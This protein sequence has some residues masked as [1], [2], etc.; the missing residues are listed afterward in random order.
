VRAGDWVLYYARGTVP[1][2]LSAPTDRAE[3]VHDGTTVPAARGE[4]LAFALVAA[5]RL[6]IARSPKLHRPRGP[7]CLRGACDG[8]LA[9]VDGVPN[10]MTCMVETRGGESVETQNVLGTRDVDALRA[11]DFLFPRGIDHHRLFAGIRGVSG[12]VQAFARR[13]AGLGRLPEETDLPRRAARRSV[14][15]LVVGGGA[16]GVAAAA[17]LGSAALLCHD[18]PRFG[19]SRGAVTAETFA[20]LLE[21]AR[22]AGAKLYAATTAIALFREP[23]SAE[24]RIHAVLSGADGATLV[25]ARAVIVASGAHDAVL[26]FD[27]NDLPG[28]Y[29]ARAALRLLRAGI[30]V[31]DRVAIA[32]DGRF[33]RAFEAAQHGLMLTRMPASAL[34]RGVGRASLTGVVL[35]DGDE[36]RR[37]KADALV[38]E[39]PGPPAYE[40]LL[41]AGARASFDPIRGFRVEL[42]SEGRAAP[43]LYAAGSVATLEG[44]S[45]D[46]G[47]RVATAVARTL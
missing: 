27:N 16:A 11:A 36:E 42:D 19:G 17:E 6:P 4:P 46:D 47:A 41:Q 34:V 43:G 18:A 45:A 30:A 40:L 14:D 32:G 33:A 35:R 26:A 12:I 7:Y 44:D 13:M 20:P 31:G 37:A 38:V 2:R 25:D 5:G 1:R 22:H 28:I 10:V 21:R 23:E 39:G 29:S 3:I 15:V 9:R 8:C 24:G